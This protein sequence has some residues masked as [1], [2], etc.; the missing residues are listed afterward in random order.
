MAKAPD[1]ILG[2]ANGSVGN[3]I[4]YELNGQTVV[5]KK[6]TFKDKPS[7]AQLNARGSMKT[8]MNLF[9]RIKPFIKMGYINQSRGTVKSYFN[10]AMSYNLKQAM[11]QEDVGYVID[12]TKLKLS[13]GTIKLAEQATVAL[14]ASGLLFNWYVDP[15]LNWTSQNDQA[16]MMAYFPEENTGIYQTSGARRMTGKDI[17][18]LPGSYL[19][20]QME[21]YL[22]FVSDDR[23]SVSDSQYLGSIN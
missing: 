23:L 12:Y 7:A 20:K 8:L 11:K 10:L 16:M 22:A 14:N 17:L 3:F 13:E 4:F 19:D 21:V 2:S 5:R 18:P 9:T 6:A 1:G 15:K